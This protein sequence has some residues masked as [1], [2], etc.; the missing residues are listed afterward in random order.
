MIGKKRERERESERDEQ[1]RKR[2][3]ILGEGRRRKQVVREMKG[4]A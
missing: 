4:V 2:R 3:R 1:W